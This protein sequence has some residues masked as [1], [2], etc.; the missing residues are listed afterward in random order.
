M[1]YKNAFNDE[2]ASR[3]AAL[4]RALTDIELAEIYKNVDHRLYSEVNDELIELII[5]TFS[6]GLGL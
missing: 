5:S 3:E 1:E 6:T 4:G 2:I